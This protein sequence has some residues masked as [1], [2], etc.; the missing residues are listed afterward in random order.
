MTKCPRCTT[1][2]LIRDNDM[3]GEFTQCLHCG[4]VKDINSS[5][6]NFNDRYERYKS[7]VASEKKERGKNRKRIL[8]GF[9]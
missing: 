8:Q 4:W 9:K 6:Y 3:Y 2:Y 7:Q 5:I 1:G